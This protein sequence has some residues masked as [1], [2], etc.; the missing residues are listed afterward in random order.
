MRGSFAITKI[1]VDNNK[2]DWTI[3]DFFKYYLKSRPEIGPGAGWYA[4][5]LV[6]KVY[7][8]KWTDGNSRF[9]GKRYLDGLRSDGWTV[10]ITSQVIQDAF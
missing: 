3:F 10:G 8:F 4:Y 5:K 1:E 9:P 7:Y 2:M 6:D